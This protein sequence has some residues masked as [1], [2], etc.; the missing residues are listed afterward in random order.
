MMRVRGAAAGPKGD[1]SYF[2]FLASGGE[3]EGWREGDCRARVCLCVCVC[4][5]VCVDIDIDVV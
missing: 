4:V 1:A 5:C 2:D 3:R